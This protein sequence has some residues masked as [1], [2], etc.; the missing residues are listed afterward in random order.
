[1][2]IEI[3]G[4][5]YRQIEQNNAQ[6]LRKSK[7]A[8]MIMGMAMMFTAQG[9]IGS[10][11]RQR[12]TPKVNIVEEFKLIHEKKSKLS[13]KDRDWVVAQFHRNFQLVSE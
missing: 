1:M 5:K 8:T 11:R 10:S 7:M 4:L 3:D 6:T 9:N 12:E 13:R 2:E